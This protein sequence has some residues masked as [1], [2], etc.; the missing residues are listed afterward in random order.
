MTAKGEHHESIAY[1]A[2]RYSDPRHH[3]FTTYFVNNIFE[4]NFLKGNIMHQ[5]IYIVG[6]IVVIMAVLSFVGL[7]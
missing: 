3:Y 1:V 6:L 5:I 4:T 2:G 7:A